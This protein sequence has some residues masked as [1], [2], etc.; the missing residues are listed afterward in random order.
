LIGPDV[1]RLALAQLSGFVFTPV[2]FSFGWVAYSFGNLASAFG[3]N[4][5][6]P[7]PD[8][9]SIVIN[10]KTGY[11]LCFSIPSVLVH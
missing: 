8:L 9:S 1:I 11:D 7:K 6:M 2:A 5:F 10:G 4:N 3:D